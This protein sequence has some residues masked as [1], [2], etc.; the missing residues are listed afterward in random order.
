VILQVCR[1]LHAAHEKGIIHRDMKPD[2]CFRIKRGG[3]PDFIKILD[4]GI[5]KVVADGTVTGRHDRP[6]MATEAGTLLGTPEYMAPEIARDQKADARVDVYSL[7]ILMYEMLTGTVPFKGQTFMATVAMQMVD[8]PQPPSQRCPE[9]NIPAPIEAVILRALRK[10]PAERYQSVRELAEA[11]VE[12]DKA[13]RMTSQGLPAL[14]FESGDYVTGSSAMHPVPAEAAAL[15]ASL[16]QSSPDQRGAVQPATAPGT[17][18]HAAAASTPTPPPVVVAAPPP[19]PLDEGSG[20][21]R[22]NPYR[23]LSILLLLVVAGLGAAIW[24]LLQRIE[25]D[26]Q[27]TPSA[28]EHPVEPSRL[29]TPTIPVS[30]ADPTTPPPAETAGVDDPDPGKAEPTKGEKPVKKAP[31]APNVDTNDDEIREYIQTLLGPI[32]RCATD[33]KLPRQKVTILIEVE[34]GSGKTRGSLEAPDGNP[35]FKACAEKAVARKRFKKG[36]KFTT[37]HANLNI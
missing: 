10:D 34:A 13:L 8:E 27:A 14:R 29:P 30:P 28:G 19:D 6:K 31:P 23:A 21:A 2:N 9:A 25:P 33:T 22:P 18:R 1:A 37:F 26:V 20:L 35:D 4:F 3:N 5:A 17:G 16:Q 24:Y 12:A 32:S 11:I 36:R 7:G 15:V